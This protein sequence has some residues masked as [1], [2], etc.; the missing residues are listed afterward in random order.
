MSWRYEAAFPFVT[1]PYIRET[2]NRR[3]GQGIDERAKS[4]VTRD[5]HLAVLADHSSVVSVFN[6]EL[7]EGG[8]VIPKRPTV[9]KEKP[10]I[11]F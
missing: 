1:S 9:A 3:K 7:T 6:K 10:G 4:E 11:T 5:G 2:T 8:E